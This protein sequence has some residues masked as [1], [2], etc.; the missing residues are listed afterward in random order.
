MIGTQTG[1]ELQHAEFS[2][3]EDVQNSGIFVNLA[4]E[5]SVK[6]AIDRH[7]IF[8]TARSIIKDNQKK[9]QSS[10]QDLKF[11]NTQTL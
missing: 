1:T 5:D 4:E 3:E 8:E 10:K 7:V 9:N 11:G 2:L 6:K